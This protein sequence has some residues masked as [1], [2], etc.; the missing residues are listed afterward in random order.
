MKIGRKDIIW[1]YLATSMRILSG[2]VVLPITLRLLPTEEI[3]I[4]TLFLSLITIT[5]LLDLGF[6][7]SFS[8]SVTYVYSGV[9]ELKSKGFAAA[10]TKEVDYGLLKTLLKAMRRYYSIIALTFL[11]IFVLVS[12][13]YL[14][15]VVLDKYSGDKQT[16]WIAW[17]VFG[18]LLSYELYTYY[19]SSIL[20]GRGLVKRNMQIIV[21][22]QSIRIIVTIILLLLGLEIIALVL[23]VL[24]SDL[25]NRTVSY[26][27]FFDRETKLKLSTSANSE[28][29]V[30]ETIKVLAPNSIKLGLTSLGV[31][32][33]SKAVVLMAPMFLTL[34][35]VGQYGTTKMIVDLIASL[36]VG[37]FSTFFPKI[38]EYIVHG[39]QDDIKRLYIKGF[40]TLLSVFIVL[41][42]GMMLLGNPV[43]TLIKSKTMLLDNK[44]LFV[45]IAFSFLEQNQ[46][47]ASNILLARNE[48][49]F[50][51]SNIASGIITVLLLWLM[52]KFTELGVWSLI[53]SSGIAMSLYV[54]WKWPLVVYK[55]LKLRPKDFLLTAKVLWTEN[56]N[57]RK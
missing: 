26:Y 5:S 49:P 13:Y 1:N 54:N 34:S 43:L 45:L 53:L 42:C 19:Y 37:W 36:G 7:N 12:P 40:L 57:K 55:D 20:T 27:V 29:T 6:S 31:F 17:F 23:G 56:V 38:S 32:L 50:F 14:S 51:K 30:K 15:S 48:V 39:K 21:L 35:D 52:F 10:E 3:G 16:I 46:S 11:L 47:I 41:G 8:R 44:Y 24:V 28:Q 22:S 2:I 9:K 18:A 25:V 4:W 33:R